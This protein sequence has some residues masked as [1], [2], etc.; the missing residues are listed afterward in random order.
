[1]VVAT[2][3]VVAAPGRSFGQVSGIERG[4]GVDRPYVPPRKRINYTKVV[5]PPKNGSKPPTNPNVPVDDPSMI[6][7]PAEAVKRYEAGRSFYEKGKIDDAINEFEGAIRIES[8]YVDAII[9]L[10][11]AYYDTAKVDEA[12]EEYERALVVDK[13]NIDAEFRLGRASYARKDYDTA[14]RAYSAVLKVRPDDPDAVY[15]LALTL[16]A[17]KRYDEAVPYFEKAIASRKTAFPEARINLSRC[18]YE[19]GKLPEAEAAARKALTEISGDNLASANAYYSLATALA[20]KPDLEGATDAL[21]SAVKV[22]E[23]CPGDLVSKFY[24]QLGAIYE[25][26]GE[27]KKA[28]KA[29]ETF[30][31]LAP[32]VPDYQV[33]DLREKISKLKA[34]APA[35]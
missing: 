1:M 17:L 18:Y 21:E 14:Y 19:L 9:D 35:S 23:G 34:S 22:C 29:Y 5:K 25:S 20:R 7:I 16:K 15:N 30:L 27:A 28:A 31:Q 13:K 24:L 12:I 11:D 33:Q 2:L 32:F 26:R 8:R 4:G 10:G 6:A 3:V